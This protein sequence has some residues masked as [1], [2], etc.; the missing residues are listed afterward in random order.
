[1]VLFPLFFDV[2]LILTSLAY[3]AIT[4]ITHAFTG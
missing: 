4:S 1:V 2:I 3:W